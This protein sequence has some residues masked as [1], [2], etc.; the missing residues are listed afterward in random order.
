M[1]WLFAVALGLQQGTG[2]AVWRALP[3]LALGHALAVSAAISSA[4][5]L[6]LMVDPGAIKWIVAAVLLVFGIYRLT[7][8]R[9]PR[10]GGMQIG[11]R[12]LT[13]WSALMASAHGAGLMVVPFVVQH[14]SGTAIHAHQLGMS[15]APALHATMLHTLGYLVVT[16]V[17]AVLVHWRLGL[18]LLRTRWYNVDVIWAGALVL[19]AILTP[20]I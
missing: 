7:K 4:A 13:I 10:F 19:T 9:H 14:G 6:G 20:L 16:G 2:R 11:F 15:A 1:G 5:L 17:V 8:A 3:P 12:D 18:R